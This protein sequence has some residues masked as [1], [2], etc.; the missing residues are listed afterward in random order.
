MQGM[1]VWSLGLEDPLEEE[2][3]THC[4]ILAWRIPWTEEPGA[5]QSTGFQRVGHDWAANAQ[6]IYSQRVTSS[7][8]CTPACVKGIAENLLT[9][10]TFQER[11]QNWGQ[12]ISFQMCDTQT[13]QSSLET[14][15]WILEALTKSSAEWKVR[16]WMKYLTV[17]VDWLPRRLEAAF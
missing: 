5:W 3:A 13:R 8:G 6:R 4:G 17:N 9:S 10:D 14:F 15:I 16:L 12:R 11:S 7:E 1:W 2:V